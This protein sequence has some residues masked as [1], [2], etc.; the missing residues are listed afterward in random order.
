SMN[1]STNSFPVSDSLILCV[2]VDLSWSIVSILTLPIF[3]S[4]IVLAILT[5]RTPKSSSLSHSDIFTFNMAALEIIGIVGAC[6][7]LMYLLTF[8]HFLSI[9]LENLLYI[10]TTGQL[11]FHL[12]VCMERYFAVVHP[13]MYLRLK[14]N[15]NVIRNSCIIAVWLYSF[16]MSCMYHFKDSVFIPYSVLSLALLTL[17]LIMFFC[18]SVLCVLIRPG[19]GERGGHRR[20]VDQSKCRAFYTMLAITGTLLLKFVTLFASLSGIDKN[21]TE[22]NRCLITVSSLWLNIP[23]SLI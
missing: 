1:N 4:M 17:V 13:V 20:R 9:L 16:G 23:S 14:K 21:E 8:V 22:E 2:N 15:A 3:L 5:C 6:C 7:L 19:P 11:L 12:L 10:S 18:V